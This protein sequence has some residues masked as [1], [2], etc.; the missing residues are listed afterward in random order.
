MRP[1]SAAVSAV[2][3]LLAAGCADVELR[4]I[5]PEEQP[6]FRQALDPLLRAAYGDDAA[7]CRVGVG[8]EEATRYD[9]WITRVGEG[10]CD[11][12]VMLTTATLRDLMPRAL[13]TLLA[14]DL[15]HFESR[16]ATGQARVTELLSAKSATGHQSVL[17][18]GN[19]QFTPE[20]E[21]AADLAAARLLTRVWGGSN[22][23]CMATADLYEDI[24]KNRQRWGAWLSRH[25][26]PERRVDAIVKACGAAARR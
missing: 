20:E 17:R 18:T 14:H 7:K 11:L 3:A 15:G 5:E 4:P 24:A 12:D 16:H 25:P 1:H 2:L 19:E 9:T 10:P 13:Q 22:V 21:A 26:H 23:G 8:V 6:V